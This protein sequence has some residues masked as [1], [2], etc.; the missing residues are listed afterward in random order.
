MA[1]PLP[2]SPTP[3]E[4]AAEQSRQAKER[5]RQ[6]I[7]QFRYLGYLSSGGTARVM[8]S[9]QN[10]LYM[11]KQGEVITGTFMLKELNNNSLIIQDTAT[12]VE[13]SIALSESQ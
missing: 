3:E 5:S 1:P 4:I 13:Q 7:N 2:P 10:Q 8:I 6:E 12:Q 9:Y 11:V